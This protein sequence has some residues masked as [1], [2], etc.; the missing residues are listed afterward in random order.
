M[1]RAPA[2]L[3]DAEY[4]L[5]TLGPNGWIASAVDRTSIHPYMS[6]YMAIGLV[7]QYRMC[8]NNKYL[9][10]AYAWLEW[11]AANNDVNGV[12]HDY[13]T[14][15]NGSQQWVLTDQGAN[16]VDS[17]DAYAGMFLLAAW[18]VW[19]ATNSMARLSSILTALRAAVQ[20]INSTLNPDGL[21]W[22]KPSFHVKYLED[23]VEALAGLRCAEDLGTAL[24]DTILHDTAVTAGNK[25]AQ[26]IAFMW[27]EQLGTFDWAIHESGVRVTQDWTDENAR[28]QQVWSVAYGAVPNMGAYGASLMSSYVSYFPNWASDSTIGYEVLP[29][30]AYLRIGNTSAAQAGLN[31]L[32]ATRDTNN[33]VYPYNTLSGGQLLYAQRM[34]NDMPT[35]RIPTLGGHNLLPDPYLLDGNSDGAADVFVPYGNP[36]NGV[37]P[38]VING[39]NQQRL[40]VPGNGVGAVDYPLISITEGMWYTFSAYMNV[41]TC[42]ANANI[43]LKMEWYDSNNNMITYGYGY[44]TGT[45][46]AR[47]WWSAQAP[48]GAVKVKCG[49]GPDPGI[50]F[51][52]WGLQLE[53]TGAPTTFTTTP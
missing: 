7:A 18:H 40:T 39:V 46:T 33:S 48:A 51:Y 50:D 2:T 17:T 24:S 34:V 31:T 8:G 28:R 12:T 5:Q 9:Q 11:Y 15:Q 30:W 3:P 13:T 47:R 41:V 36:F 38:S 45:G 37:S 23:N 21:T 6:S 20:S 29:I 16:A 53:M 44:W 42:P 25:M 1:L 49:A 27:N 22:A 52:I 32:V 43:V 14:A 10:A 26:G 35:L 4:L 19:K